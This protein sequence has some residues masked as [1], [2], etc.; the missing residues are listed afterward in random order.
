MINLKSKGFYPG[1]GFL[2]GAAWPS[3]KR[4]QP[5]GLI[6]IPITYLPIAFY[7]YMLNSYQNIS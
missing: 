4:E 6:N 3:M 7:K 2:H 5:Y 1:P